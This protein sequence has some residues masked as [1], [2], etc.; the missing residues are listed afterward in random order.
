[1]DLNY[2]LFEHGIDVDQCAVLVMRHRPTEPDLRKALPWLAAESPDLY[3]A[4]Q[5]SHGLKVEKQLSKAEYLVSHFG[6]D[7]GEAVFVGVYRVAGYKKISFRQY[8]DMP[9]NQKLMKLGMKGH[10]KEED[11]PTSLWFDLELTEKLSELKG[12][13]ITYWHGERSWS[14]WAKDNKFRVKAILEESIL[15][16]G[17]PPLVELKLTWN[18]LAN[19]PRSWIDELKRIRGV[20]L[21]FD[22]K[23]GRIYVGSAYG[24]E[25][26]YGRWSN[27]AA[28]GDGGNK[29][30]RE[31]NPTTFHFSIL[32]AVA[33]TM[34]KEEV[35]Q[36]ENNWKTRLHTRHPKFGLNIN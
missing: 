35:I 22:S 23:D 1:M 17:M 31:R 25:N 13:L 5:Q 18:E 29:K 28:S 24:K 33:P 10:S 26:L 2:L 36:I 20:Y 16:K 21:I 15:D 6:R 32:Q 9:Q 3:N 8:W 7:S 12:K 4:F 27:Y 34:E 11:R 30:L 19:L 14:R